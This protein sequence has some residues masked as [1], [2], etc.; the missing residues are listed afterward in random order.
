MIVCGLYAVLW[1]KGKE[2]KEIY[3]LEPSESP[4]QSELIDIIVKSPK[5]V[6]ISSSSGGGSG[7]TMASTG[8]DSLS[9]SNAGVDG[10]VTHNTISS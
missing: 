2:M 4:Q 5:D 10:K 3:K 9:A 7:D 1:G 6:S 8:P